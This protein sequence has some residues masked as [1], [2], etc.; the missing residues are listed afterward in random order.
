MGRERGT[1]RRVKRGA[2]GEAKDSERGKDG[3]KG[4]DRLGRVTEEKTA[5]H[6]KRGDGELLYEGEGEEEEEHQQKGVSEWGTVE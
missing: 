3:R 6:S 1:V 4:G 5:G 2:E